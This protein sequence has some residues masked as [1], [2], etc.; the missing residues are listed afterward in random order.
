[1][2]FEAQRPVILNGIEEIATRADLLDRAILLYLPNIPKTERKPEK[3]F[4]KDFE[5]Q[6]PQLLGALLDAV[7]G[8]MAQVDQVAVDELPR[9]ADFSLWATAAEQALGWEKGSF[10]QAYTATCAT[11][12]QVSREASL[13]VTPLQSLA[14]IDPPW[15]GTATELLTALA[16]YVDDATKRQRHWPKSPKALSDNLRRLAPNLRELGIEVLFL[17]RTM[18]SRG[19]S[20]R[21]YIK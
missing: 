13:L 15:T 19:M 12:N 7:S 8:T 18:T 6:R 2:L 11:A 20:V 17:S 21:K 16:G 3:Q 5:A 9:M 1:M 10:A 4:W 14:S